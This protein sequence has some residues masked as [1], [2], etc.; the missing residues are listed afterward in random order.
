VKQTNSLNYAVVRDGKV[1]RRRAILE[2]TEGKP[3]IAGSAGRF[4][5]TPDNRLFVA[6]LASGADSHGRS[7]FENR[8]VEILPDGT[9]GAPVRIPL[10]KPFTSYFTATVRAGSAPSR[11]LDILGLRDGA[12]NTLSYARVRLFGEP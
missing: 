7:V 8:I 6:H 3:G 10:A 9:V 12:P 5:V 11:T 2:T 4:C 1:I